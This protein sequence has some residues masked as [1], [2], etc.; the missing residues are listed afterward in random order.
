MG[1]LSGF[2]SPGAQHLHPISSTGV[3]GRTSLFHQTS[4]L[5][6][7]HVKPRQHGQFATLIEDQPFT[8]L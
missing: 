7:V 6:A 1:V 4:L 8:D 5:Y 2:H 3:N